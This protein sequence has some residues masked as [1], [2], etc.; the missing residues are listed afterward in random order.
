MRQV[1]ALCTQ[2]G[3]T[4]AKALSPCN[5]AWDNLYARAGAVA[6]LAS[7]VATLPALRSS[8]LG[9]L[10]LWQASEFC[11]HRDAFRHQYGTLHAALP[12]DEESQWIAEHQGTRF[13]VKVITWLGA[14]QPGV[15]IDMI[16]SVLSYR[17]GHSFSELPDFKPLVTRLGSEARLQEPA[18][19]AELVRRVGSDGPPK[20]TP[21]IAEEL[22]RRTGL[23]V[24]A[25]A[26]L[27][28]GN[29]EANNTLRVVVTPE[30]RK[31]LG[32]Q[33]KQVD[34]ASAALR[35]LHA[36]RGSSDLAWWYNTTGESMP[37]QAFYD[38]YQQAM[39]DT[40]GAL[41]T[42]LEGGEESVMARL[43]RAVSRF[44]GGTT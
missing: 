22:A 15:P 31:A 3:P 34:V 25:A 21:E 6:Y 39:P 44:E 26:L 29:T 4:T 27:W 2:P 13:M 20:A 37:R 33:V 16:V 18:A 9:L 1:E 28:A 11:R 8:L 14:G 35:P 32:L 36:W 42:P 5:V 12:R 40:P 10:E 7:S 24:P 38:I 17:S 23:P 19:L 30:V 43:A 41:W